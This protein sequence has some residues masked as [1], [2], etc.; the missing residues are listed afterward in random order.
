M[1]DDLT[2]A[3]LVFQLTPLMQGTMRDGHLY[4]HLTEFQLTPLMRGTTGWCVNAADISTH[5][6]HAR[7]DQ[8]SVGQVLTLN[9]FNSRPSC[10]GRRLKR[11]TSPISTHAPRMRGDPMDCVQ[12]QLKYF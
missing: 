3:G 10:E 1:Y 7:D 11:T 9:H 12:V 2:R 5:A 4:V 6:P 8:L